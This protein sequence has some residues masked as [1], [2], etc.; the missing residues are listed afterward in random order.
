MRTRTRTFLAFVIIFAVTLVLACDLGSLAGTPAT[1][2]AGISAPAQTPM[3]GPTR[4]GGGPGTNRFCYQ[5]RW[6]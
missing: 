1:P 6:Q 3:M 4:L 5:S 2:T